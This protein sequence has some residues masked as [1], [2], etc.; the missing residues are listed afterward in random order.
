MAV[1]S[2]R[3]SPRSSVSATSRL[4]HDVIVLDPHR[5]RLRHVR[6]FD[7]LGARLHCDGVL[8]HADAG[9][10]TPGLAGTDVEFPAVPG[11]F[12]HLAGPRIAVV[13]GFP[14]LHEAG[15]NALCEAAAA[16]R[17]AIV[18]GEEVTGEVEHHDGAA[19]HLDEL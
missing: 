16:M 14:G 10:I 4:D 15:L 7:E 13:A 5:E 3:T 1:N 12:H 19:V 2:N 9:R 8:P 6:A 11:A 17:A 18:E